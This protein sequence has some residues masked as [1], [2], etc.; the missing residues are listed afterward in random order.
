MGSHTPLE[1]ALYVI[2]RDNCADADNCVQR[3]GGAGGR[4]REGEQEKKNTIYFK[5]QGMNE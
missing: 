5:R 3:E 1:N 2:I 4:S